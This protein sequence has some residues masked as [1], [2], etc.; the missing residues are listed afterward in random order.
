[1][2]NWVS[3]DWERCGYR[4]GERDIQSNRRT[5]SGRQRLD[6]RERERE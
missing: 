1:L 2:S 3:I 4:P 5:D 6:R